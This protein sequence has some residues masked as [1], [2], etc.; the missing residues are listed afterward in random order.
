MIL[1][2]LCQKYLSQTSLEKIKSVT[3]LFSFRREDWSTLWC[4]NFFILQTA[5]SYTSLLLVYSALWKMF[6]AEMPFI[7]MIIIRPFL[8]ASF[9]KEVQWVCSPSVWHNVKHVGNLPAF[10]E[11]PG[12]CA[13]GHTLI[14]RSRVERRPYSKTSYQCPATHM[15]AYPIFF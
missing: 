2:A 1:L 5:V 13:S 12:S 6:Q 15:R 7:Y 10:K 14:Y 4:I 3:S 11:F 9:R 8:S